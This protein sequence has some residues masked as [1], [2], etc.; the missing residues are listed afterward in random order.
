MEAGTEWA[1]DLN[2]ERLVGLAEQLDVGYRR[3]IR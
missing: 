3:G 1:V 2:T